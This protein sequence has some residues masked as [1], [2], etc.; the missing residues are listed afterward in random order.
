MRRYKKIAK[1]VFIDG[2]PLLWL[3]RF[4]GRKLPARVSGTDLVEKL[5]QNKKN[6][7]FLLGSNQAVLERLAQKL[8]SVV[9]YYSPPFSKTFSSKEN[10]KII[11]NIKQS[12]AEILLVAFGSLKQEQW[13]IENFKKTQALAGVGVGS[14]FE[15]LSGEKPRAPHPLQIFGLEWLWRMTLEPRRLARRYGSDFLQLM[16]LL[17]TN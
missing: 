7:I 8:S 15:I 1:L 5:L 17:L 13:L 6:R 14:A 4:A 10:Q 12:R 2:V 9:G 3:F 11:K 16:R